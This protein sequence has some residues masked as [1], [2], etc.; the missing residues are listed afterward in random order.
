[1]TGNACAKPTKSL[2]LRN[3]L[4]KLLGLTGVAEQHQN[5]EPAWGEGKEEENPW[6]MYGGEP[7]RS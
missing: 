4:D 2:S 7:P 6:S 1:M 5:D 3:K